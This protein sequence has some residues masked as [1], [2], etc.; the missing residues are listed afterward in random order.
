MTSPSAQPSDTAQPPPRVPPPD[1]LEAHYDFVGTRVIAAKV[2]PFLGAGGEPV[3]AAPPAPTGRRTTISRR[4]PSWRTYLAKDYPHLAAETT[5]LSRISQYVD[6]FGGGEAV[7]FEKL[8]ELFAGQ[9]EPNPLHHLLAAIPA[10]IRAR[11]VENPCQFIVTTNYDDALERAFAAAGEPIDVVYYAAARERAGAV[12]P[13]PSRRQAHADPQA[14]T[15]AVSRS[16]SGR[17]SSR[18]TARSTAPTSRRQLRDHR[19]PLHRLRRADER[20][21]ADPSRTD[22]EDE[23]E[24]L[25][26]PRLRDAR[27]EPARDPAP[28]LVAADA[29]VQVVGDPEGAGPDRREVLGPARGRRSSTSRSTSGSEA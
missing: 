2:I 11:G 19:G 29:H 23:H 16:A 8:R 24:P 4:A 6:L 25:P 7:L 5:D 13:R 28:H 15:T 9:Y 3:L 22:G 10:A 12:R 27:L 20:L 17:C 18:S 26:L 21:Q 1:A 14:P